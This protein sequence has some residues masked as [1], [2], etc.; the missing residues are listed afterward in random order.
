MPIQ[1]ISLPLSADL[2]VWPKDPSIHLERIRSMETGN[3]SNVS[4]LAMSVHTGTHVD[5]PVHFIPGAAGVNSLSLG[6]LMGPARVVRVPDEVDQIS[7][8]V[9]AGLDIPAGTERLLFRTRNSDLWAQ[10][11]KT[12]HSNFV[13]LLPDA[14]EVLIKRGVRLLGIDYLSI[15]PYENGI[16]THEMLLRAGVIVLEGINLSAVEPG[17]YIL[18][19]LPLLLP[20]CDGAP[21]RAVLTW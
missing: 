19:C 10:G 5:A 16:P 13:A 4:F 6:V 1:D 14:A 18:H 12:F 21:A 2:P 20:G 8:A 7:K 3:P 9:L 11:E 15:A 17:E